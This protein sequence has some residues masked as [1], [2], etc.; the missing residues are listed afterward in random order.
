MIKFDC[1]LTGQ[2]LHI[3]QTQFI[4][5]MYVQNKLLV[6]IYFLLT[7]SEVITG[8]SQT[9]VWDFPVMTK[10]TMLIRYFLYGLFIVDL[11]LQSIKT[12]NRSA[13]NFKKHVTLM[14]CSLKAV[15]Q[16]GDAG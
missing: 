6:I 8:K 11:S 3:S 13:D 1:S 2:K 10:W 9:N 14:S 16:S 5:M 4:I 7:D 15:F 12:N